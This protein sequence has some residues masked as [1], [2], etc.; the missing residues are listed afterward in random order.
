MRRYNMA[1]RN[2]DTLRMSF[3]WSITD[4]F[5][6]TG[7]AD[8]K[9]DKYPDTTL[10][11][12]AARGTMFGLD[13]SYLWNNV[14]TLGM[15]YTKE[16]QKGDQA[17]WN[18]VAN[19]A[20]GTASAI[21]GGCYADTATKNVNNKIDPCNAWKSTSTDRADS[22]GL[23]MRRERL[24]GGKLVLDGSVDYSKALTDVAVQGGNYGTNPNLTTLVY[25]RAR[26]L[27]TVKA[28]SVQLRLNAQYALKKNSYL[29]GNYIYKK[30][31]SVDFAYDGMQLGTVVGA[32]P[33]QEVAPNYSAHVFWLSY[34]KTFQ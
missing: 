7:N 24:L 18:Y 28:T 13:A 33:T 22:L 19:A 1:D 14:L 17:G 12:T 21:V 32:L 25:I 5:S 6:L 10:G 29:R 31:D 20:A 15:Y 30:L 26:D 11:L 4:R 27:P 34:A 16:N 23:T 8:L 3:D 9:R 2:R